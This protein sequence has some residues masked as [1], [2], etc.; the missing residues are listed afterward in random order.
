MCGP[1]VILNSVP[2]DD[3]TSKQAVMGAV[4]VDGETFTIVE[5][6]DTMSGRMR[7]VDSDTL[8]MVALEAGPHA[9]VG[10][11]N[12]R[13]ADAIA[14]RIG[15]RL[16]TFDERMLGKRQGAQCGAC[17]RMSRLSRRVHGDSHWSCVRATFDTGRN[18]PM[19]RE[20][21]VDQGP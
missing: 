3:F 16:A 8:T 6:P 2:T 15:A 18:N 9:P 19:E 13:T 1:A 12:L 7:V 14:S 4:N 11:V 17:R 5:Y 20:I 10:R 21:D